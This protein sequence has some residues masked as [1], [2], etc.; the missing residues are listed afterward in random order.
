MHNLQDSHG[1]R[2]LQTIIGEAV[3]RDTLVEVMIGTILD[4]LRLTETSTVEIYEDAMITGL[5][6]P[7][8]LFSFPSV[9]EMNMPHLVVETLT[10]GVTGAAV[11]RDLRIVNGILG[12]AKD[13]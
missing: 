12:T 4:L 11:A 8:L 1:G 7:H 2:A 13:Q 9:V 10:M 6:D 5:E 3:G